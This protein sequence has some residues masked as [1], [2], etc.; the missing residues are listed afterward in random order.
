MNTRNLLIGL[1]TFGLLATPVA[2]A[3]PLG[4]LHLEKDVAAHYQIDYSNV[5]DGVEDAKDIVGEAK[6]AVEEKASSKA[7]A[8]ATATTGAGSG[9]VAGIKE[10]AMAF[11]GWLKGLYVKPQPN[12]AGY[13]SATHAQDT[14]ADAKSLDG[15]LEGDVLGHIEATS[16]VD[17]NATTPPEPKLG[18]LGEMRAAFEAFL[19]W[20]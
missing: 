7:D 16:V 9:I 2:L 4:D 8:S 1:L 14:I 15:S 5:L 17:H 3:D 13:V 6:A 12:A 10:N 19:D 20:G 18:F 11:V